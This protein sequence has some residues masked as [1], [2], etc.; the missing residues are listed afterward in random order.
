MFFKKAID[1]N[2]D[3]LFFFMLFL[4]ISPLLPNWL[5]NLASPVVGVPFKQFF[6]ATLIGIRN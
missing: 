4:R 1:E 2:H 3:N 6:F 5:I